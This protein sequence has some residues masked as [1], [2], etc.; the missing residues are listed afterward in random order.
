MEMYYPDNG[1]DICCAFL[2]HRSIHS[3]RHMAR[4]LKLKRKNETWSKDLLPQDWTFVMS[5]VAELG[6]IKCAEPL[7]ETPENLRD[8]CLAAGIDCDSIDL[9]FMG[10]DEFKVGSYSA[11]EKE[12]VKRHFF[13]QGALRVAYTLGRSPSTMAKYAKM[14]LRLAKPGLRSRPPFTVL[15][16][17][18]NTP[19]SPGYINV[20]P[21]GDQR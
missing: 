18:F 5:R 19:W 21:P 9:A 20:H 7:G 2:P 13:S 12:Y 11:E 4:E 17:T 1:S 6:F 3:V 14:K 16:A 15:N 10:R 8:R